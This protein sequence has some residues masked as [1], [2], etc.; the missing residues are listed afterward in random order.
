MSP[1]PYQH[2]ACCIEDSP[3]SRRALDEARR[4]GSFG[5]SR[6]TVIHVAPSPVVYGESLGMPPEDEIAGV[7]AG[8]LADT[9]RPIEDA[10]PVLLSGHPGEA[11]SA[12]A[13]EA[14]PDLL[15]A[16][17]HRGRIERIAL[18]SFATY[19][20]YHAPCHVLLVRPVP[21]SAG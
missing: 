19:V 16:G 4:L 2:I 15:V 7:A 21:P 6:L 1:A 20:A 12:W 9:V 18:G 8:W 10:E 14:V 3:G 13:R 17:A 11:V 5:Q